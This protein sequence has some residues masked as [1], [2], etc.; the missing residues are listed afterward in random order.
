MPRSDLPGS[1]PEPWPKRTLSLAGPGTEGPMVLRIP[2]RATPRAAMAGSEPDAARRGL[3][4]LDL[5]TFLACP[6][7][8]WRGLTPTWLT[9]TW[10]RGTEQLALALWALQSASGRARG[11]TSRSRSTGIRPGCAR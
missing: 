4:G 8:T 11:R 3:A 10:P 7:Q 1:D 6:R 9:P 5:G 2:G